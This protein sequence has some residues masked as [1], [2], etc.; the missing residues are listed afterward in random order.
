MDSVPFG[1][2]THLSGICPAQKVVLGSL[3]IFTYHINNYS[4]KTTSRTMK[5]Y[6]NN[7][8]FFLT[9]YYHKISN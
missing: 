8:D 5:L 9:I 7:N 2:V 3:Y 4:K 1:R 6:D